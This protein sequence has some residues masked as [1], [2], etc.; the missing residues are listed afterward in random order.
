MV[1]GVCVFVYVRVCVGAPLQHFADQGF[2]LSLPLKADET[3]V[4]FQPIDARAF[5]RGRRG[6]PGLHRQRP[7]A[8]IT[9]PER[10]RLFE[11]GHRRGQ[12]SARRPFSIIATSVDVSIHRFAIVARVVQCNWWLH[13]VARSVR[14]AL[15][16]LVAR[17]V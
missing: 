9:V 12:T 11:R 4:L 8:L 6:A 7:G 14:I 16:S 15:L 10:R 2:R 13:E 5:A 3:S 1:V 17:V